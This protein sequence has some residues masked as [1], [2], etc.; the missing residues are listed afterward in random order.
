LTVTNAGERDNSF[1][2]TNQISRW[3]ETTAVAMLNP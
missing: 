1:K 2:D 3:R